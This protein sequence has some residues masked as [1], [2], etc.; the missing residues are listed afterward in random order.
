M[1][2]RD[3]AE[4]VG[5]VAAGAGWHPGVV[6]IVAAKLVER[7]GRPAV[8]LAISD[9]GEIA[10]GSARSVPGFSVYRALKRIEGEMLRFGGHDA[11]AGMTVSAGNLDSFSRNFD[12]SV[13]EEWTDTFTP[14]LLIDA[15]VP[16]HDIG[17]PLI[18][19][20]SLLEPHGPGNPEPVL[21]TGGVLL[22]SGR[23]VGKGHLKAVLL[24]GGIRIEAIGFNL[25]SF[26]GSSPPQSPLN[27]AFTPQFNFWNGIENLQLKIKSIDIST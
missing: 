19:Q 27:V 11:A 21:M 9:D 4:K 16:L 14:G 26:V 12:R 13:R 25:G 18:R 7:F 20:L 23:V 10:R 22:E 3:G 5:L 1:V 6:G 2:E 17:P 8:V 24:Q 15:E